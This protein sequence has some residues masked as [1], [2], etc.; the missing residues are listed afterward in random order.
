M[1]GGGEVKGSERRARSPLY[2]V[3]FGRSRARRPLWGLWWL[4]DRLRADVV[5]EDLLSGTIRVEVELVVLLGIWCLPDRL[6]AEVVDGDLFE[7]SRFRGFG[8]RVCFRTSFP[9]QSC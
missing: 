5:N 1:E 6:W 7:V 9:E 2:R 3:D 4:P 8:E